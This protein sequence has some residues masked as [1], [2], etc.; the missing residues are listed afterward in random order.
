MVILFKLFLPLFTECPSVS[1]IGKVISFYNADNEVIR[2]F[3]YD[4]ESKLPCHTIAGDLLIKQ[5]TAEIVVNLE[6]F[7]TVR[8]V[9]RN[10][11]IKD[12]T[13]TNMDNSFPALKNVGYS[14]IIKGNSSLESLNQAFKSLTFILVTL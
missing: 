11:Y 2:S 1:L 9:T 3:D 7:S 14:V 4:S 6:F 12:T 5:T 10:I 8:E 13:L